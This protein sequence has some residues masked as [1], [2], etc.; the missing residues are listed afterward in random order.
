MHLKPNFAMTEDNLFYRIST[1]TKVPFYPF[2]TLCSSKVIFSHYSQPNFSI[3]ISSYD[4]FLTRKLLRKAPQKFCL[5]N[6]LCDRSLKLHLIIFYNWFVKEKIREKL[7]KSERM[8]FHLGPSFLFTFFS[9]SEK[10]ERDRKRE[11]ESV[12]GIRDEDWL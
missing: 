3:Q 2:Y 7:N 10:Y 12:S 9:F 1:W 11:V 6:I 4:N 8:T 5:K